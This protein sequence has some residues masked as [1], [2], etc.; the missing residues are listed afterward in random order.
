MVAILRIPTQERRRQ[1]DEKFKSILSDMRPYHKIKINKQKMI[2]C[3]L[4]PAAVL[5]Y[6]GHQHREHFLFLWAFI[7]LTEHD[8]MF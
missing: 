5:G 1:K 4:G 6:T 2:A 7:F 3:L 8:R